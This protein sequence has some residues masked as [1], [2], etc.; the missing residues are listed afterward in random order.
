[1]A[2]WEIVANVPTKEGC[3]NFSSIAG[4]KGNSELWAAKVNK[5]NS[6]AILYYYEDLASAKCTNTCIVNNA[7]G[8][9]G[10]ISCSPK[11]MFVGCRWVDDNKVI[12]NKYVARMPIGVARTLSGTR[13]KSYFASKGYLV[14]VPAAN[15]LG[16]VGTL[17]YYGTNNLVVRD[18]NY[19]VQNSLN[20]NGYDKFHLIKYIDEI[21]ELRR[22]FSFYTYIPDNYRHEIEHN[23]DIFFDKSASMLYTIYNLKN[24]ENEPI[25]NRI[26]VYY[27]GESSGTKDGLPYYKKIHT[28]TI[29]PEG[30]PDNVD[31]KKLEIESACLDKDGKLLLCGNFKIANGDGTKEQDMI[32]RVKGFN[33]ADPTPN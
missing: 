32:I 13:D 2:K 30:K 7:F 14:D 6:K 29:N 20:T 21:Y 25:D 5:D 16:G 1:M 8:H 3:S 4:N 18:N 12:H 9:A 24:G 31:Y 10:G 15:D 26:F 22:E 33:P 11:N 23:Q 17:S 27:L 28:I 19:L